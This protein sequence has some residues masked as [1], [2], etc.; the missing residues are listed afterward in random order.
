MQASHPQTIGLAELYLS[1]R[2]YTEKLCE[3]LEIE[4][5]IPQ[6]VVDVSPPKWN[7]AHTT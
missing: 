5:Y 4:D 3:P 2:K 7:V 6:P 1:V